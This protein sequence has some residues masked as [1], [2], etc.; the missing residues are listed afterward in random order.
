MEVQPARSNTIKSPIRTK[1]TS[2]I[3]PRTLESTTSNLINKVKSSGHPSIRLHLTAR[4]PDIPSCPTEQDFEYKPLIRKAI[5]KDLMKD[6]IS[7]IKNRKFTV[8]SMSEN[9]FQ[10]INQ[11]IRIIDNK[12]GKICS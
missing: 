12:K 10:D 9:D 5:F 6:P 7:P 2:K 4:S 8:P 1:R 3:I 11:L